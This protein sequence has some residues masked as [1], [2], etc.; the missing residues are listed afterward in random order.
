MHCRKLLILSLLAT[1][2][3]CYGDCW[4]VRKRASNELQACTVTMIMP[5]MAGTAGS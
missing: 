3:D 1:C 2:E 5:V 4:K